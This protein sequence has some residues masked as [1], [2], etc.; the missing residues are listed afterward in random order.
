MKTYVALLRGINVSGQK[1]IKMA[2]LK[3]HLTNLG[4][5]TV[6]TYIQ[7][8]NVVFTCLTTTKEQLADLIKQKIQ[9]V[10]GFDVPVVILTKEDLIQIIT[11]NPFAND[12]TKD[13]KKLYVTLLKKTVKAA[14]LALFT[15]TNYAPELYALKNNCVYLFAANGYGR[16]KLN[17]QFLERKLQVEATTRNWRTLNKLL[18]MTK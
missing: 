15:A 6:Q 4:L 12:A 11:D 1:K 3:V 14:Q 10:Y 13:S 8:G 18:E 17:N 5:E 7:S 16:A 9:T 2:D